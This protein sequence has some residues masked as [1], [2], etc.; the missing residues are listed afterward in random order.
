M[1][2]K[3]F[4][5]I[6]LLFS[7]HFWGLTFIP[8][9][10]NAENLFAWLIM[11]TSFL[12]LIKAKGLYF[13]SAIILFFV[14]VIVNV[15]SAYINQEQSPK[16]TILA[17]SPYYF[18]LFYFFLH[19]IEI[20]VKY[21]EDIIIVF[22]VLY[23]LIYIIQI[24]VQPLQ[25]IS[26]PLYADRGT[27]RL[28]IE[29]NGFLVFA[30]FLLINRFLL[31]RQLKN[32]LLALGF[33]VVLILGG[34]RTL[35]LVVLLLSVIMFVKL[36]PFNFRNYAVFVVLALLFVGLFQINGISNI[37]KGMVASTEDIL[38]QGD[39]YIRLLQLDFFFTEF[40]KNSSIYFLGSGLPGG[41]SPYY[42]LVASYGWN[43]G[44]YWVDIGLLG[45]YLMIGPIA[46]G[47]ILWYTV[48]AMFIKLPREKLYLNLYFAY[49][50]LVS[51]TT[52]EIFREGVFVVQAIG[53]YLIDVVVN[54]EQ[55]IIKMRDEVALY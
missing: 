54:E 17:F 2:K 13:R 38:V 27:I 9:K 10:Y 53:L 35:T 14:G 18:I 31:N 43:F 7:I 16:A 25:I 46:I 49:L 26:G 20:S 23:S 48:K 36:V 8:Q 42:I 34:F 39:K 50:F 40:P 1:L 47:A 29:G 11:G 44:F 4:F 33:F 5:I 24:L 22:A 28:R 55:T 51:F 15:F 21:L 12:M 6:I 37:L 45:L 3:S 41:Y 52:M 19:K 30:Y 32:I